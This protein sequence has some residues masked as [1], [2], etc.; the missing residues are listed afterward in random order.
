MSFPKNRILCIEDDPDI[1]GLII[2]ILSDNGFDV[3]YAKDG[4]HAITL[5]KT[6]TFDLYLLGTHHHDVGGT[7]L[8]QRF[9]EFDSRT[10]ILSYSPAD[11]NL[12]KKTAEEARSKGYLVKRGRDDKLVMEIGRLLASV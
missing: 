10:P 7:P 4:D 9:R 12:D 6:K 3:T 2:V 8:P 11:Y 1:R 5:A